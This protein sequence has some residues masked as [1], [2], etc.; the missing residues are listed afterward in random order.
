MIL[1]YS[2]SLH[3]EKVVFGKPKV[4]CAYRFISPPIVPILVIYIGAKFN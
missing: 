2:P 3:K 4:L 1:Q